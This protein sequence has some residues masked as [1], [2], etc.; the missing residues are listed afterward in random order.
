M[1]EMTETEGQIMDAA[2]QGVQ[3]PIDRKPIALVLWGGI[4]AGKSTASREVFAELGMDRAN[5]VVI[6]VDQLVQ[7][8]PEFR[9]AVGTDQEKAAYMKYRNDAKKIQKQVALAVLEKGLDVYVEWTNEENLHSLSRGESDLFKKAALEA[10]GYTLVLC[11]VE[12]RDVDGILEAA[13]E[14]EKVD[15]RHIPEDVIR[16]YNTDRAKHWFTAVRTFEEGALPVRAFVETR[17]SSRANG[18]GLVELTGGAKALA[19]QC[20]HGEG[21]FPEEEAAQAAVDKLRRTKTRA[22]NFCWLF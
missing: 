22:S 16:K 19:G 20:G 4:A 17:K 11:L 6:D 9:A 13:K 15:G 7:K 21:D 12:C 10:K 3:P 14:R 5:T 1:Q 2:M 8:V 18:E